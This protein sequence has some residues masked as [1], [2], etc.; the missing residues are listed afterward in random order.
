MVRIKSEWRYG[1][2]AIFDG[3][4]KS[5]FFTLAFL[6]SCFY[7]N[8][9]LGLTAMPTFNS[10]TVWRAVVANYVTHSRNNFF[11][12]GAAASVDYAFFTANG[13]IRF[14]PAL[15][16][17]RTAFWYPP[18][19]FRMSSMG[20]QGNLDFALAAATK[21]NGERALFRPYIQISPTLERIS[22]R[23]D[24]FIGE[25]VREERF[26]KER[27]FVFNVA[28]SFMLDF[29]ASQYVSFA[30]MAGLRYYPR[31]TWENFTNSI[32][33]GT[34]LE[35]FDQVDW[36]QFFIGGRVGLSLNRS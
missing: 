16:F 27:D 24:Y 3:L 33:R 20:I 13:R 35:N 29:Q 10:P 4:M 18:D 6:F 15:S 34:A 17:M 12:R 28:A 25:P 36:L 32:S 30:P 19:S 31:L 26:T 21:A 9:Q 1:K 8:A 14:R 2:N 22:F 23:Y 5:C 7:A 11:D